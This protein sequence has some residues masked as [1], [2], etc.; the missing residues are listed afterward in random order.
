MTRT[1]GYEPLFTLK[2][3]APE[4]WVVDGPILKFYGLPFPT[5][6]VVVRLTDGGLWLHSPIQMDD[7]L[8]QALA[9]LG[10]V[11]HLMAPN[12]I[13]YAFVPDWQRAFPK[14]QTWAA[15]GVQERAGSRGLALRVDHQITDHAPDAWAGQVDQLVVPG[16]PVHREAV[17]FHRAS[18]TLILTDLI[19]NFEAANLPV[20]LIPLAWAAG[21]L[22]PDGK[23]PI[24]M[25]QTFRKGREAA[26]GAIETML[27]WEPE[28][29]IMAHGRWYETG[30]MAELNRAFRWVLR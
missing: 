15:P 25:R 13:H 30:A 10:P 9:A 14:A 20:W 2:P 28:R 1:T 22:D 23:A 4:I 5:R 7:G 27:S 6:M 19:E 17:F 29:L 18:K 8:L 3:V 24:D 12:W 16:S 11:Q 26:R 21:T